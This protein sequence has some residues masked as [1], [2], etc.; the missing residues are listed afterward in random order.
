[1]FYVNAQYPVS[2]ELQV[3][4]TV[5]RSNCSNGIHI[6]I[7]QQS[8]ILSQKNTTPILRSPIQGQRWYLLR[9]TVKNLHF[10]YFNQN[11]QI[12]QLQKQTYPTAKDTRNKHG[13]NQTQP[14]CSLIS[15]FY[16][17]YWTIHL[18][19]LVFASSVVFFCTLAM[20]AL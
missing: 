9:I 8:Q 15:S 16:F 11:Q 18:N 17:Y 3:R 10:Y 7:R 6:P 14:N 20:E 12:Q 1:M 13:M 5:K 4:Q 2:G 19:F